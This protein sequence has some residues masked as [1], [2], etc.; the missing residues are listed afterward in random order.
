MSS[1]TTSWPPNASIRCGLP[2]RK[3]SASPRQCQPR[4]NRSGG[5]PWSS[6]RVSLISIASH[7]E[8]RALDSR[9]E[10]VIVLR[11]AHRPRSRAGRPQGG[12][13]RLLRRARHPGGQGRARLGDRRVRGRGRLQGRDQAARHRRVARHRLARGVG[14][15]GPLDDRPAD[16]HRRGR[17][18]RRTDP[19]PDAQHGRADDHALRHRRAEGVLPAEDPRRRPALLD[20]LLRARLRHRPRLAQDQGGPRGRRVGDQRPEDV[21]LADPVRRLDLAGLP[22]RPRPAPPQGA[23]DDP[24]ADRRRRVLLHA[25]AHGRGGVD[26][27]D[28]LRGRARPG[29][30]PGRRA[31]RRLAADHQPA[32]PRAGLAH[33]VG[34]ADD[35]AQ[36]GPRVGAADQE[37]GRHR[38]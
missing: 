12:A 28:V 4:A 29:G 7:S 34:A 37:P 15:P 20:R 27:R 23:L 38:A 10:H 1:H 6:I 35:V 26:E 16:L 22:H 18:L 33:L 30:Q 19:L 14:R 25:G 24:G 3:E 32:Q 5:V 11:H 17:R 31:E 36:A 8:C 2:S 9:L 21:D 13:A